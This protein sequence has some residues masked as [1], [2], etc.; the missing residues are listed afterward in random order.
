[1]IEIIEV[2]WSNDHSLAICLYTSTVEVE[3]HMRLWDITW[4]NQKKGEDHRLER[5]GRVMWQA[6]ISKVVAPVCVG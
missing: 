3:F 6:K 4:D 1:V 5:V 2:V